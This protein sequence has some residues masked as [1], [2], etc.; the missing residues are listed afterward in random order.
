MKQPAMVIHTYTSNPLLYTLTIYL[1]AA[2]KYY[3]TY[4]LK[5]NSLFLCTVASILTSKYKGGFFFSTD[6]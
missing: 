1:I 3:L 5:I 6:N 4:V 2:L